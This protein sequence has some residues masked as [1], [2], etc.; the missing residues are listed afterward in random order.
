MD[1]PIEECEKRDSKGLYKKARA[2]LIKGF[3]GIDQPYESPDHPDV[4][5]KTLDKS[6]ELYEYFEKK[7]I[8]EKMVRM[9]IS[10]PDLLNQLR[11]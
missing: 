7:E 11:L 8:K 3:T 2:G 10:R 1:T 9:F 4:V 5:I 6:Y